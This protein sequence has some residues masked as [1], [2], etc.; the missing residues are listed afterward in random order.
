MLYDFVET[1]IKPSINSD[2]SLITLTFQLSD[3]EKRG[4]GFWKFNTDLL[5]DEIY[6]A[7]IK[8]KIIDLNAKYER[9]NNKSLFWDVIKCELHRET[10]SYSAFKSKKRTK[11]EF[12]SKQT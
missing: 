8:R 2:H 10:I 7:M 5:R 4:R 12:H 9:F 1:D 11:L 3:T 6:A